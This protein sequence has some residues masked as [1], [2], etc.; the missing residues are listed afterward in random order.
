MLSSQPYQRRVID[1]EV[2]QLIGQ[3]P[4]IV[5]EGAKGVGKTETA[6]QRART[7]WE[8]DTESQR[9]IGLADPGQLLHGER[10]VLIDEWQ[11]VPDVWSR[12][13]RAVDAGAAAGSFLMTG[14]ALPERVGTHSGAGRIVTIRMRPLS[15]AERGLGTPTV[16]LSDLL[17][18]T[19]PAVSGATSCRVHDYVDEIVRSGFPGLRKYTGHALTAQLESYVTRIVDHDFPE[20]G[21]RLR[22]PATL[23]AW[24]TA[25]AAATGTNAAFESIR[26]A[27]TSGTTQKPSRD[28]V[29]PYK[30]ILERLWILD[31]VPAWEPTRSHLAELTR[32]PKHH[33]VDPALAT[34]L[35][36]IDASALLG[37]ATPGLWEYRDGRFLGALFDSLVTQSV[38]VYAQHSKATVG[39]FRQKRGDHE[40]DLIVQR[41]DQRVVAIEIKFAEVPTDDDVRHLLWLRSQL[42][43][44]VLDA[45]VINTGTHAY[46]R[47]DGV[48][49]VPAALLGA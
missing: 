32:A 23:R 2:D 5:F 44:E 34:T 18:G 6:K 20:L 27:A 17:N 35:L 46:R 48:A 21:H 16:R 26:D 10:P 12:V 31:E 7:I 8:L 19:S 9:A 36:G 49:V 15:L 41:R 25:Y 47:P 30:E 45:V 14:S 29:Q 3:L 38:R 13:R 42:G 24:M 22:R 43:S 1:D 4:A 39:H 37:G 11:H 28:T 33:L 40:V